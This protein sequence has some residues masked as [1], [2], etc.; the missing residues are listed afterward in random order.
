MANDFKFPDE[1]NDNDDKIENEAFGAGEIS[2]T[3]R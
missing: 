3:V 1:Q 2:R